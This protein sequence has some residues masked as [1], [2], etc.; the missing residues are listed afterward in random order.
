ME[1]KR[2]NM[3]DRKEKPPE[4]Q[5]AKNTKTATPTRPLQA[6]APMAT[7]PAYGFVEAP[8]FTARVYDYLTDE[9]YGELQLY[10][11]RTPDAGDVI[12]GSGGVRK[13]RWSDP[14]RKKG[15][16]GGTRV[17]YFVLVA[18]HQMY[19]LTIYDKDEMDDLTK[20]EKKKLKSLVDDEAKARKDHREKGKTP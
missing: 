13:V 8:T 15:K 1:S 9:E 14:T 20:A 6:A 18:D 19:M 2:K 12:Q 3:S 17:I 7:L 5:K 11:A 4:K 16:R 10:L